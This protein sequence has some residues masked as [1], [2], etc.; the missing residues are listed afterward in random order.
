MKTSS[1]NVQRDMTSDTMIPNL[2]RGRVLLLG[3][4]IIPSTRLVDDHQDGLKE[5][6]IIPNDSSAKQ[7][8]TG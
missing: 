4:I 3:C 1:V 7:F 8:S 2:V 5:D 6:L